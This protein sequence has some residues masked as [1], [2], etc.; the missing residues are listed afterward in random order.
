MVDRTA[1]RIVEMHV[2]TGTTGVAT[3]DPYL[4]DRPFRIA[5]MVLDTATGDPLA[6]PDGDDASFASAQD[7]EADRERRRREIAERLDTRGSGGSDR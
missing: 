1:T 4:G 5:E 2:A 7:W 6:G 3:A